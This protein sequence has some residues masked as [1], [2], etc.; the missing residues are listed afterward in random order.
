VR[1]LTG[2][3]AVSKHIEKQKSRAPEKIKI[4]TRPGRDWVQDTADLAV[5]VMLFYT[6]FLIMDCLVGN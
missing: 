1:W 4:E 2:L 5:L 3:R 6:A